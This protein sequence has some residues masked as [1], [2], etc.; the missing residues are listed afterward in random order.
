LPSASV[1]ITLAAQGRFSI[2]I[3]VPCAGPTCSAS[4][5][6]KIAVRPSSGTALIAVCDHALLPVIMRRKKKGTAAAPADIRRSV[7]A[8]T[9]TPCSAQMYAGSV[10]PTKLISVAFGNA[11][12]P[13]TPTPRLNSREYGGP[14]RQLC[15]ESTTIPG[16]RGRA[17]A[18]SADF[19]PPVARIA[20]GGP[21][22]AQIADNAPRVTLSTGWPPSFGIGGR[23]PSESL[24]ALLQIPHFSQ[25]H[26]QFPDQ[27]WRA[28]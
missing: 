16:T 1:P 11:R 8:F 21:C 20:K 23:F 25:R 24:A 26:F 2:T 27:R 13:T 7:L 5:R 15:S 19:G 12:P 10:A 22:P 4:R 17:R 3:V 9:M 6:A 14:R 18:M 28:A